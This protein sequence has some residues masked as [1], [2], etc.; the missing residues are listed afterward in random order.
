MTSDSLFSNQEKFSTLTPE[1]VQMRI[2]TPWAPPDAL[3][4]KFSATCL[5]LLVLTMPCHWT[6]APWRYWVFDESK[7]ARV[8]PLYVHPSCSRGSSARAWEKK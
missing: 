5:S 4:E 6:T 7:A 8:I 1:H 3:P 2:I